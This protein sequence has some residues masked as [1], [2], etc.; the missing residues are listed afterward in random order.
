M[1]DFVPPGGTPGEDRTAIRRVPRPPRTWAHRV[2]IA[3]AVVLAICGLVAVGFFV[4][5]IVGMSH[6]GD[7]K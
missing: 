1:Q 4:F 6:F 5:L 3:L 2:G 7:N